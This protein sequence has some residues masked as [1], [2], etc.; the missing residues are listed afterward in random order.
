MVAVLG[1]WRPLCLAAAATLLLAV[2]ASAADL[3]QPLAPL[4]FLVGNW[5]AADG[6]SEGGHVNRGTATFE[7][8]AAG[9]ALLRQDHTEVF[10]SG[11]HKVEDFGQVM[12]IY[13]E[14]G[15]L[16][17]DYFDGQH[18]L[19]YTSVSIDPNHSVRFETAPQPGAPS[20]RLTYTKTAADTLSVKFEMAPPGQ[21]GLQ[22]IAAGTMR[23]P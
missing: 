15:K 16:R 8:A 9:T 19:H 7:P 21:S 4:Q 23:R 18:P 20:F 17:A 1:P 5:V 6:H 14:G 3:S 11:G 12:L 13:P 10:D 22:E 2:P